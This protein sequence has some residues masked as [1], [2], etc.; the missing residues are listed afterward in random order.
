MLGPCPSPLSG[1]PACRRRYDYVY[2]GR[3]A[4]MRTYAQVAG[5]NKP[6]KLLPA[7]SLRRQA[8]H[9]RRRVR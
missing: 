2:L 9:T 5:E 6:W 3:S 7:N 1:P 8:N 4:Y